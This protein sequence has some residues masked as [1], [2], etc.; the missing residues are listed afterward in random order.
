MC[1]VTFLLM[2]LDIDLSNRIK[3]SIAVT[4]PS[5]Q[6]WSGK[7]D[8]VCRVR[9]VTTCVVLGVSQQWAATVATGYSPTT[10]YNLKVR[11]NDTRSDD[12]RARPLLH[13]R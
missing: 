6:L 10:G 4:T 1:A 9:A 13:Q 8:P 11:T 7:C 12:N 5:L 3:Q 2:F